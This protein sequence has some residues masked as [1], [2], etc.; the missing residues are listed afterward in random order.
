MLSVSL[1]VGIKDWLR[2]KG[3]QNAKS[4][5]GIAAEI[6]EEVYQREQG[7]SRD[8]INNSTKIAAESLNSVLYFYI[9]TS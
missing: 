8:N 7:Q 9:L 3:E 4:L 6:L 1:S 5:Q 2:K